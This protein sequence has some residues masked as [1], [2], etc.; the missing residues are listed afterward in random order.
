M[1]VY[2]KE[3]IVFNTIINNNHTSTI[4]SNIHIRKGELE[5]IKFSNLEKY[6]DI[7]E[8]CF[9]TRKGGVSS[10]EFATL[11]LGLKKKDKRENVIKNFTRICNALNIDL[12][13]AVLSDQVHGTN[14]KIVTEKDRGKGIFIDSDIIACDGLITNAKNV[15]LITFYADCVPVFLFDPEKRVIGLVHSGWKGTLKQISVNAVNAM[16]ECFSCNPGNIIS[17]I[18][19]SIGMCCFEVG[20]EVKEQFINKISWSINYCVYKDEEKTYIDLQGIVKQ[21]L[22]DCGLKSKNIFISN[23]CTKCNRNIFFSHRGDMG[24]TGSLA[25]I[26]QL[27]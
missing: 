13:N 25:A 16:V 20:N 3:V 4:D 19:P 1:P 9:T 27:K 17:A 23:I 6:A 22:T 5:Y 8:H 24:K 26:M 11:N 21:T 15:A 18:G 14:V 10:S 12:S 2:F 7:I